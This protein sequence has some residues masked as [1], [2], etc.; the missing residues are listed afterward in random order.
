MLWPPAQLCKPLLGRSQRESYLLR[1]Q[2][3][4][5]QPVTTQHL[6]LAAAGFATAALQESARLVWGDVA[7]KSTSKDCSSYLGKASG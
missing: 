2:F 3:S 1:H 6:V 7:F 4:C 5:P